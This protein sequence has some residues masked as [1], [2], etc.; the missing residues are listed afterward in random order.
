MTTTASAI[1]ADV[2]RGVTS[3]SETTWWWTSVGNPLPAVDLGTE[4]D[5]QDEDDS[6]LGA[7]ARRIENGQTAV[8]ARLDAQSDEVADAAMGA[9]GGSVLRRSTADVA[10]EVAAAAEARDT[11]EREARKKLRKERREARKE[12]VDAK[13]DALRAKFHQAPATR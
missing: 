2:L 6:V 7:F 1:S 5:N 8:L 3:T 4:A 9:L 11:A 13:L 12:D 10:A